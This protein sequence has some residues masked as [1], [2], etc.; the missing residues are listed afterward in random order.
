MQ[1]LCPT[2]DSEDLHRLGEVSAMK[3]F[4]IALLFSI[5]AVGCSN[6]A[7]AAS[8]ALKSATPFPDEVGGHVGRESFTDISSQ[9]KSRLETLG[10]A[11]T[12]ISTLG[13]IEDETMEFDVSLGDFGDLA[14]VSLT[15][16]DLDKDSEE[17]MDL[18]QKSIGSLVLLFPSKGQRS[19]A[20]EWLWKATQDM[21]AADAGGFRKVTLDGYDL[22]VSKIGSV[23][24]SIYYPALDQQAGRN[25]RNPLPLGVSDKYRASPNARIYST[26]ILEVIED[27]TNEILSRDSSH[28][29]P[30]SGHQYLLVKLKAS[31]K[32]ST[33][34]EF[35]SQPFFLGLLNRT[36][37]SYPRDP[38][39]KAHPLRIDDAPVTLSQGMT[40]TG[41]VCFQVP[42]S[43]VEGIVLHHFD[44]DGDRRYF[45]L[46]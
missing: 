5:M 21:L 6:T 14:R 9:V 7:G 3:P 23:E 8:S 39:C 15:I 35:N 28:P 24:V 1:I 38:D 18:L 45:A 20:E 11:F 33:A 34:V 37:I 31:N 43:E 46:E 16:W 36:G 10:Y 25:E 40:M 42:S 12:P 4:L 32:Q 27:A 30:R 17:Q 22:E 29:K 19:A 26:T 41:N 44:P 2:G 13:S